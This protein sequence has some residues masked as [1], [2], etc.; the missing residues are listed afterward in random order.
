MGH[1]ETSKFFRTYIG[2]FDMDVA[3]DKARS[4]EF[5][6]TIDF[7]L[8]IV[9]SDAGNLVITDRNITFGNR[10]GKNIDNFTVFDNGVCLYLSVS[11][12]N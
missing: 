10:P 3:V 7:N 6:C 9:L 5:S 2:R 11:H 8:A 1:N 4:S 12:L